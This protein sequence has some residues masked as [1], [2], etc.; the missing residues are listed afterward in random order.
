[1]KVKEN[2][3]E[4]IEKTEIEIW[5]EENGKIFKS[6]VNDKD[7]IWRR[8]KRKEYSEVMAIKNSD[9]VDERIY[10]RQVAITKIAVLNLSEEEIDRDLNDLAGLATTLSEEIMDKSGFNLTATFEL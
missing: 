6:I 2:E 3:N 9:D 5:K 4:I 7:Y 8:L 10:A 1:M